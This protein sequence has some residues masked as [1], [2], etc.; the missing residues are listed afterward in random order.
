MFNQQETKSGPM[1]LTC[2]VTLNK[3]LGLSQPQSLHLN[4][5]E[6]DLHV[7]PGAWKGHWWGADMPLR[8]P[9]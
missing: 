3:C 5:G 4:K 7:T 1:G 6:A 9:I 2:G 8:V